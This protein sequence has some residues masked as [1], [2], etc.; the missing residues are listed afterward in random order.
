MML[1]SHSPSEVI[2]KWTSLRE[3]GDGLEV[4]GKLTLAVAK[5]A[6]AW[7]LIKDNAISG[8]SI[9]YRTIRAAKGKDGTRILHE[10]DLFEVS[11]V[12]MPA[13]GA[14]RIT[15]AKAMLA[16]GQMPGRADLERLL[17]SAG[18]SKSQAL[19]AAPA[20]IRSLDPGAADLD[21]LATAIERA[22]AVLL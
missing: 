9:G 3:T 8:L 4:R 18:M 17:R 7:A 11:I 16:A 14:A 13:A 15:A 20:V 2:G 12:G 5:A 21:A 19:R 6:E 1:W 22:R 10:V